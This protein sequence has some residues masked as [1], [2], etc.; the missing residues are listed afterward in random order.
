M[1]DIRDMT[2]VAFRPPA[3]AAH[4]ARTGPPAKKPKVQNQ[5]CSRVVA[6]GRAIGCRPLAECPIHATASRPSRG[7]LTGRRD[8]TPP[9]RE[10]ARTH[11]PAIARSSNATNPDVTR[12]VQA[13]RTSPAATAA[14]RPPPGVRPGVRRHEP[15]PTTARGRDG[16]RPDEPKPRRRRSLPRQAA[17]RAVRGARPCR[18]PLEYMARSRKGQHQM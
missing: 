6:R 5:R 18:G 13:A 8:P 1:G 17:S 10:S 3:A 7:C 16:T 4:A 14:F 12:S 15:F 11:P 9:T 2:L